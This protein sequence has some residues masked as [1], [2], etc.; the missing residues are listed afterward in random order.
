MCAVFLIVFLYPFHKEMDRES[1][2]R[3]IDSSQRN[4][5]SDNEPNGY[6]IEF[7]NPIE[8]VYSFNI[9]EASIP[10]TMYNIDEDT[11]TLVIHQPPSFDTVENKIVEEDTKKTIKV[12]IGN[13]SSGTELKDKLNTLLS[14]KGIDITISFDTSTDIFTFQSDNYFV[15][16]M[17]NS[18]IRE[19]L[20]FDIHANNLE[21]NKYQKI[22]INTQFAEDIIETI[23]SKT[24]E[25]YTNK[26]LDKEFFLNT[27][28]SHLRLNDTK[29]DK[30]EVDALNANS[31]NVNESDIS[32]YKKAFANTHNISKDIPYY[33]LR[34]YPDILND[35]SITDGLS[36]LATAIASVIHQNDPN[37]DQDTVDDILYEEYNKIYNE[38]ELGNRRVLSSL[39][40]RKEIQRMKINGVS[41]NNIPTLENTKNEFLNINSLDEDTTYIYLLNN[42]KFEDYKNTLKTMLT[43]NF[44]FSI[45]NPRLYSS[46]F[47]EENSKSQTLEPTNGTSDD[48]AIS[49]ERYAVIKM[50]SFSNSAWNNYSLSSFRIKLGERN[51]F[52]QDDPYILDDADIQFFIQREEKDGSFTTIYP[53]EEES[54]QMAFPEDEQPSNDDIHYGTFDVNLS[55]ELIFFENKFTYYINVFDANNTSNSIY[56]SIVVF[57]EQSSS[58]YLTSEFYFVDSDIYTSLDDINE[59]HYAVRIERVPIFYKLEAPGMAKLSGKRLVEIDIPQ[60]QGLLTT[61]NPGYVAL[62]RMHGVGTTTTELDFY[63]VID[64]EF[65]PERIPSITIY[66]RRHSDGELYKTRGVNHDLRL[67]F[68]HYDFSKS[69]KLPFLQENQSG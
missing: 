60:I 68:K 40:T 66:L 30:R 21:P 45:D 33:E 13:Y 63:H 46:I 24:E 25:K 64:N 18:T 26:K 5:Y 11:N 6:T 42:N 67:D 57:Y 38:F 1:S 2:V 36:Y 14:N 59:A 47:V 23:F 50:D 20:G 10:N 22:S 54:A 17:Q 12:P 51:K 35:S 3:V 8:N 39:A 44:F 32:D 31:I 65:P 34:L 41:I 16:D 61:D 43:T 53:K 29:A 19:I 55:E 15:L 62:I 58:N 48:I 37:I 28:T 27:E 56:N 4:R 52:N 7:Q 9:L 49:K 69:N